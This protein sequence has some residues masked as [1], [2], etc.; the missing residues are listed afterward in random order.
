LKQQRIRGRRFWKKERSEPGKLQRGKRKRFLKG[1]SL[2][3]G[4]SKGGKYKRGSKEVGKFAKAKESEGF[5]A[6][7]QPVGGKGLKGVKGWH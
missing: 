2:N 5:P 7:G 3:I 6:I 1:K 4:T